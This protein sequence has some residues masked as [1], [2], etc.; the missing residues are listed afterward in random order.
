MTNEEG[1]VVAILECTLLPVRVMSSVA[2]DQ[3]V[4]PWFVQP[5]QQRCCDDD[6]LYRQSRRLLG[7]TQP[8]DFLPWQ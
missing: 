4:L 3:R 5:N 2:C 6:A 7:N 1:Q 8:F